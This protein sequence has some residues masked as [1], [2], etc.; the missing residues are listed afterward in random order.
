M[1]AHIVSKGSEDLTDTVVY[2]YS[3]DTEYK[4]QTPLKPAVNLL[5]DMRSK[6]ERASQSQSRVMKTDV[7]KIVE[8][9]LAKW[10]N[11]R[12]WQIVKAV[13]SI[14]QDAYKPVI[15]TQILATNPLC[16]KLLSKVGQ[17]WSNLEFSLQYEA[18]VGSLVQ[19]KAVMHRIIYLVLSNTGFIVQVAETVGKSIDRAVDEYLLWDLEESLTTV[20]DNEPSIGFLPAPVTRPSKTPSDYELFKKP[21]HSLLCRCDSSG[22]SSREKSV[23]FGQYSIS[24]TDSEKYSEPGSICSCHFINMRRH[25]RRLFVEAVCSR[26]KAGQRILSDSQGLR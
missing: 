13:K 8:K 6:I 26:H 20:A 2:R 7:E 25:R 16:S 22:R 4:H 12:Q 21:L 23:S 14:L 1:A 11:A 5:S 3:N 18:E 24:N 15:S 10:T 9:C 17:K 19:K